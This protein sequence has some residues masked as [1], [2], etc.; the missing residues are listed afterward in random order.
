MTE[1]E[2]FTLLGSQFA[3]EVAQRYNVKM[4]PALVEFCTNYKYRWFCAEC[5]DDYSR[6]LSEQAQL[7]KELEVFI[8]DYRT[9]TA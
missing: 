5:S 7:K 3:I 1:K 8:N 4:T 6:T 9:R 2:R